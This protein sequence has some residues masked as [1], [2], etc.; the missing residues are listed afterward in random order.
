MRIALSVSFTALMALP[1]YADI[2]IEDV[3]A[4]FAEAPGVQTVEAMDIS[5]SGVAEILV[6]L[7]EGCEDGSCP[8]SLHAFN[9]EEWF[10]VSQ[11]TGVNVA[12]TA[13]G[14]AGG[15]LDVDGVTWA[16]DGTTLYPFG[17]VI[18]SRMNR[19]VGQDDLA[20]IR[21]VE[22][23]SNLEA[24]DVLA[25]SFEYSLDGEERYGRVYTITDWELQV[26]NWGTPWMVVEQGEIIATG[27]STDFP[28]IF[29]DYEQG[30]YTVVEVHP[31]GYS[32]QVVR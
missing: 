13:T 22:E 27:H 4:H 12:L 29:P 11:G 8:W 1:A 9:G 24:N 10:E 16:F 7:S 15:V 14:D 26:G 23:Y 19:A 6:R 32:I 3:M 17:D 5:Q 31:V 25:W 18:G 2:V 28:R 30:G 21:S 20:I